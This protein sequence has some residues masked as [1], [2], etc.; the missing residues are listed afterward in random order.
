MGS[1]VLAFSEPSAIL[2]LRQRYCHFY[3]MT[4][5]ILATNLIS[6]ADFL[7]KTLIWPRGHK[8]FKVWLVRDMGQTK[9]K[10]NWMYQGLISSMILSPRTP[11]SV[12]CTR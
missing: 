10:G 8:Y 12:L 1:V 3:Y 5:F 9:A 2:P 6:Q 7:A 11:Y 4:S